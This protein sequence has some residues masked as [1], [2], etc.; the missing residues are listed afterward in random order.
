[1]EKPCLTN[2][3]R[4]EAMIALQGYR[5]LLRLHSAGLVSERLG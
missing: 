5:A 2:S 3:L 1:V 4:Q